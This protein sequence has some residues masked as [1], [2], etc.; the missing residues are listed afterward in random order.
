MATTG[1]EN[2]GTIQAF[3]QAQARLELPVILT[4]NCAK[5]RDDELTQITKDFDAAI[6]RMKK[7]SKDCMDNAQILFDMLW[8]ATGCGLL[9]GIG[10]V[11]SAQCDIYWANLNESLYKEQTNCINAAR[12]ERKAAADDKQRKEVLVGE[13]YEI[14]C[15]A[16]P[17]SC[18]ADAPSTQM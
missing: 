18:K 13:N 16:F 12:D 17:G 14:C 4:V 9:G 6:D 11:W 5:R 7:K 3:K 8:L 2:E 15:I 10:T 1:K